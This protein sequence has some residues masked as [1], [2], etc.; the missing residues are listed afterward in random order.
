[1]FVLADRFVIRHYFF[2]KLPWHTD[3]EMV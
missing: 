3:S 1:V 2:E